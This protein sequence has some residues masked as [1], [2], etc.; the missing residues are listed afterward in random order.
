MCEGSMDRAI[1]LQIA[2]MGNR[3]E[4]GMTEAIIFNQACRVHL[5][6]SAD[7]ERPA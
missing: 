3:P 4:S 7:T 2:T 6:P 1:L 5:G